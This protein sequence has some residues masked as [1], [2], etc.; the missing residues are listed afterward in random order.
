MVHPDFLD[1]TIGHF[2]REARDGRAFSRAPTRTRADPGHGGGGGAGAGPVSLDIEQGG[3]GGSG[4]QPR[5]Q[6]QP[7]S[8]W[9]RRLLCWRLGSHGGG[10]GTSVK[11]SAS[12]AQL[13]PAP[14]QPGAA[15]PRWVPKAKAAFLQTPQGAHGV[16]RG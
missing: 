13:A 14:G 2:Y 5:G 9:W 1:R 7:A 6:E 12:F 3:G 11:K 15:P 4:I 8:S 16:G 10:G